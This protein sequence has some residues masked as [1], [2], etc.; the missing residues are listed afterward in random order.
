MTKM[1]RISAA[2]S[3]FFVVS[4]VLVACGGDSVP[5]DGVARVGDN[6]VKKSEFTHWMNVAAASSQAAQPGQAKPKPQIPQ[7]PDFTACVA[8]K[9]KAAPKPAKGQPKTTDAQYKS[10][11]KQEYEGMRDQVLQF[12]I[13]SQWITGESS[14]QSVKVTDAEVKKQFDA[15]K[16]QSFPKDKDFQNYLKTSGM[17]LDDLLFRFRIQA[18]ST[19]L[20]EKIV[21]GKGT[22]TDAQ[23][24]GYYNKNKARFAQPERRDLKVVLAKTQAKAQEARA[25]LDS[26]ASWATV[27]KKY[28]IDQASKAQGGK[29]LAVAKGQQEKALDKAVFSAKKGQ[30]NGPVKTQFG[31]YDF[32]VTKVTPASQQT[33]AQAKPT[34]K[35]LLVSQNEQKALDAFSKSYQKKWKDRTN[36]RDGFV[37]QDCKNAPKPKTTTAPPGASTATGAP[38]ATSGQ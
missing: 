12:L 33:L 27:A 36:C 15:A 4:L 1:L 32:V 24:S 19:K 6:T 29:L 8:A 25:Q 16:K 22:V 3:A 35:Q 7:P 13:S 34:I 30:V 5:G 21:K 11:C 28:S 10:Q 23:I 37:T 20:R 18:L 26:G 38:T 14:E 31:Y 9:K 2:L 17:T